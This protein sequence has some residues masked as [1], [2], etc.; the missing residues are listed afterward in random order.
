MT[1]MTSDVEALTQLLQTGLVT[2]LSSIVTCAGIAIALLL[3]D[4]RLGLATLT[5]VVPL[6][7]ATA[8]FR[9]YSRRAY[10][11]SRERAAIVNADFPEGV[12]GVRVA[13]AFVREGPNDHRFPRL[14][15]RY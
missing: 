6:L 11:E 8:I 15:R 12:A 4:W 5:V 14:S 7:A 9:H 13:P 2:A 1:R 3:L 10:S